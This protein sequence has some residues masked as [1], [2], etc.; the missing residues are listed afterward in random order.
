MIMGQ[1]LDLI[2]EGK[3]VDLEF[4]R[5]MSSLKTGC[6]LSA[7]AQFGAMLAGTDEENVKKAAECAE[8]IG[9]AFQIIDDILDITGSENELG[10]PIGS[11]EK[12]SKDTYA[13]IMGIDSTYKEAER[14]TES[15]VAAISG[16]NGSE[17][18]CE[19]AYG[20][21]NRKH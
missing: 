19:L 4:L 14:Y 17:L 12:R 20:L 9:L 2:S 1:Q 13:T 18:L 7:S 8:N 5:R 10:K 16:I 21:L 3:R 11:D 15:A 6:I